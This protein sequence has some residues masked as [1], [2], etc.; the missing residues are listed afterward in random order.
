MFGSIGLSCLMSS[1]KGYM[2]AAVLQL[3]LPSL[4]RLPTPAYRLLL[5]LLHRRS[6]THT[7]TQCSSCMQSFNS[8]F[9]FSKKA[10]FIHSSLFDAVHS[11]HLCIGQI[12]KNIASGISAL[13]T[14]NCSH[15]P[16]TRDKI[17][18]RKKKR[19][20]NTFFQR[21]N[22]GHNLIKGSECL[23]HTRVKYHTYKCIARDQFVLISTVLH[24]TLVLPL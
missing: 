14:F 9:F 20:E 7:N 19:N 3:P 10:E 21:G 12:Q 5:L 6:L 2:T 15:I 22:R 18:K 4:L 17:L 23:E 8:Q 13:N 1:V 16:T 24:P 11:L